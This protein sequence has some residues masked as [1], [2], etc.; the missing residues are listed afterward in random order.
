MVYIKGEYS[1][2]EIYDAQLL[3]SYED[4]DNQDPPPAALPDVTLDSISLPAVTGG[5]SGDI[6]VLLHNEVAGAASGILTVEVKDQ[7]G[8][9]LDDYRTSFTT[10]TAGGPSLISFQW[11]APTYLTTVTATAVVSGVAEEINLANNSASDSLLV[12]QIKASGKK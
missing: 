6:D 9:L 10:D 11:T 7:N 2:N 12:K 5:K 8:V 1:G 4:P 3:I